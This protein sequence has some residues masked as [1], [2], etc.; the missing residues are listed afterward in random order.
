MVNSKIH[1]VFSQL[2]KELK[3]HSVPDNDIFELKSAI[4]KDEGKTDSANKEYGPAVKSWFKGMIG[5]A[6][7]GTWQVNL[8]VAGNIISGLLNSYYGWY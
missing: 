6:A 5:K 3:K 7:E 2:E 4:E 1:N 8:G